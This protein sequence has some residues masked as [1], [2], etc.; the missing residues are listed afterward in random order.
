MPSLLAIDSDSPVNE[1]ALEPQRS[2]PAPSGQREGSFPGPPPPRELEPLSRRWGHGLRVP[3]RTGM[4]LGPLAL[5]ASSL[6]A[7]STITVFPGA[8]SQDL[9]RP[10]PANAFTP[11]LLP[12]REAIE[13][14]GFWIQTSDNA[15][16]LISLLISNLGKARQPAVHISVYPSSG[17]MIEAFEEYEPESLVTGPHKILFKRNHF[18][19]LEDGHYRLRFAAPRTGGSGEV[20]GEL[21]FAPRIQTY[22]R[23]DGKVYFDD[24]NRRFEMLLLMPYGSTQGHITVDGTVRAIEG[25]GYIDHTSQN[26]WAHHVATRWFNY[27]FFSPELFVACTSFVTPPRYGSMSISHVLVARNGEPLFASDQQVLQM[28]D[29]K[30]DPV[31][32]YKIPQS[33][34]STMAG[35]GHRLEISVPDTHFIERMD[36]LGE[37]N[38]LLRTFVRAFIARPYTYRYRQPATAWLTRRG[39]TM[40]QHRGIF[41]GELIHV[42]E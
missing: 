31:S 30:E 9:T 23:G 11:R 36:L 8:E 39:G 20:T 16:V 27:R 37:V 33:I 18:E 6:V 14:Y 3:W 24:A 29:Q 40:T 42:N 1:P 25:I 32:G 21:N 41:V 22:Q 5:L 13:S 4:S 35:D 34:Y 26:L 17:P 12:E 19:R 7:A 28:K 15:T 2:P 10:P 38:L